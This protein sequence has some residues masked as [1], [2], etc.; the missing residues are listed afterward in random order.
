MAIRLIRVDE[1]TVRIVAGDAAVDAV[2]RLSPGAE[3]S[4]LRAKAVCRW[5]PADRSIRIGGPVARS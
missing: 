3:R 4:G 1:D 5:R 2:A